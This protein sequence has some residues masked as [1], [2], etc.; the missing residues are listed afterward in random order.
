MQT[1]RQ[2]D[3]WTNEQWTNQ[4]IK[5]L[6]AH[7]KQIRFNLSF[8]MGNLTGEW[9]MIKNTIILALHNWKPI[10]PNINL[11]FGTANNSS[12]NDLNEREGV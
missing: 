11:K 7:S 3:Q 6:K 8:K 5:S 1:N 9:A 4:T 2:T 12:E 10:P